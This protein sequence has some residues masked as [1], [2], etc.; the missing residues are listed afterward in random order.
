MFLDPDPGHQN[1]CGSGSTILED[2]SIF[3][4]IKETLP[5]LDSPCTVDFLYDLNIKFNFIVTEKLDERSQ[6]ALRH[7]HDPALMS[8]SEVYKI[9]KAI[10]NRVYGNVPVHFKYC[11]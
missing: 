8:D 5:F 4:M 11:M 7:Q 9:R 10:N 1:D 2:L 3:Q 6:E